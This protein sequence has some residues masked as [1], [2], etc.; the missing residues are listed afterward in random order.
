MPKNTPKSPLEESRDRL[1]IEIGRIAS[2]IRGDNPEVGKVLNDLKIFLRGIEDL[3]NQQEV[4]ENRT[5]GSPPPPIASVSA[6]VHAHQKAY[7]AL[8]KNALLTLETAHWQGARV[9][10]RE[11]G[12]ILALAERGSK[13]KRTMGE[14]LGAVQINISQFISANYPQDWI[15]FSQLSDEK[16][17]MLNKIPFSGELLESFL[18]KTF[19]FLLQRKVG[20][21]WERKIGLKA[22]SNA[23]IEIIAVGYNLPTQKDL[24]DAPFFQTGRDVFLQEFGP[25]IL[26]F[27]ARNLNPYEGFVVHEN[28]SEKTKKTIYGLSN[29]LLLKLPSSK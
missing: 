7:N 6:S 11:L 26:H 29:L 8:L 15:D 13:K 25:Q 17:E 4:R 22:Q 10:R 12:D 3:S 9:E 21:R 1:V 19:R 5:E 16:L 28:L 27:M 2:K 18:M 24:A 23:D 14:I 20:T